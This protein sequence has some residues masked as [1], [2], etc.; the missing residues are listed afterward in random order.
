VQAGRGKRGPPGRSRGAAGKRRRT[1]DDDFIDP[2]G[3]GDEDEDD[4]EDFKGSEE[5]QEGLPELGEG[6]EEEPEYQSS[7]EWGVGKR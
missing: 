6:E 5:E 4:D 7:G 3:D 2:D 1:A